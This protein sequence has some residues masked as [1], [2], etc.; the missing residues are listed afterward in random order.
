MCVYVGNGCICM[1]TYKYI[2][3]RTDF[4]CTAGMPACPVCPGGPGGPGVPVAPGTPDS[5]FTPACP[6]SPAYPRGPG[7]KKAQHNIYMSCNVTGPL[8]SAQ[9]RRHGGLFS[10]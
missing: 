2:C 4:R 1:S 3:D 10:R 7:Y 6:G 5:P 9:F 8:Y